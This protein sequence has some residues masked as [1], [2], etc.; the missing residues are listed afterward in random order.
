[1]AFNPVRKMADNIAAIR[2]ALDFN[3]QPLS[4]RELET[5]KKYAGFGGLK[6]V[7]FPPGELTEWTKF[8]ASA[9]DVKLYPQVMEL[10]TLLREKLTAAAYKAAVDALKSSSQTAYYTPDYIPRAIYAA[11]AEANI[12]PKR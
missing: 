8:G 12:L 4:Q 6:A 9:A 5:L 11:M 1:M 10:H 7:L 2:I 3:G